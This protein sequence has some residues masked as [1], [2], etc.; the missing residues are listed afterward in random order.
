MPTNVQPNLGNANRRL[1]SET[2]VGDDCSNMCQP[3]V[4][5]T[6]RIGVFPHVNLARQALRFVGKGGVTEPSE[7]SVVEITFSND[8]ITS[9]SKSD[10]FCVDVP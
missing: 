7:P 2:N 10:A 3:S 4:M 5:A 8:S 6:R 1:H 9:S